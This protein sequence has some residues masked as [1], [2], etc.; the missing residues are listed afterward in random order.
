MTIGIGT[1]NC[2]YEDLEVNDQYTRQ[3]YRLHIFSHNTTFLGYTY[4]LRET[5]I[6]APLSKHVLSTSHVWSINLQNVDQF[7]S[8]CEKHEQKHYKLLGLFINNHKTL[9]LG[10]WLD[11]YTHLSCALFIRYHTKKLSS[12]KV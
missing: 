5:S 12:I 9:V 3:N 4:S 7:N 11:Y 2:V 8:H 10:F 1:S 6:H